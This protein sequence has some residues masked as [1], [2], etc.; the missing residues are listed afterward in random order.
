[1]EKLLSS[2]EAA[3]LLGVSKNTLCTWRSTGR[4]QI[5][6]LK[7]GRLV[8]YRAA[9]LQQFINQ[10]PISKPPINSVGK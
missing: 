5:K 1:M 10:M 6:Y 8:K 9:D 4:H 2:G 7:I 3:Q